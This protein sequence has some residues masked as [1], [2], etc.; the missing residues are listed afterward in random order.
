M[1][2]TEEFRF[3]IGPAAVDATGGGSGEKRMLT[4]LRFLGQLGP[5]TA[6]DKT[7]AEQDEI[8]EFKALM[9]DL[10][11]Q[12]Q[13]AGG[14]AALAADWTVASP[15][16]TV[17]VQEVQRRDTQCR[18]AGWLKA[19]R[20]RDRADRLTA[21]ARKATADANAAEAAAE[22]RGRAAELAAVRR[23]EHAQKR[24]GRI[25]KA[26]ATTTTMDRTTTTTVTM[27]TP[28]EER[29]AAMKGISAQFTQYSEN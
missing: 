4:D 24:A 22:M 7:G 21:T 6:E 14:L 13:C 1:R 5:T 12:V 2:Q 9:D 18:G 19:R 10:Q 16:A 23:K 20:A 8:R 3:S 26:T 11:T 17:S 27:D 29:R 15:G 25:K 28:V